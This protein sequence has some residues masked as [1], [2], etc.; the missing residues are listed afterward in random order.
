MFGSGRDPDPLF[1]SW[2]QI[3]TRKIIDPNPVC[4]KRL[5]PDPKPWERE[6]ATLPYSQLL[7][8]HNEKSNLT[9]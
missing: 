8:L 1:F 7:R 6:R 2:I 9:P 4:V 5:G 3:R